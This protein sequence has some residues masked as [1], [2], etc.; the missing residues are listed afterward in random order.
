M[1]THQVVCVPVPV[2]LSVCIKSCVLS[3][4]RHNN[5]RRLISVCQVKDGR[6]EARTCEERVTEGEYEGMLGR[7]TKSGRE[8]TM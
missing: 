6:E 8:E 5:T 1:C 7:E 4:E 2:Y 3:H